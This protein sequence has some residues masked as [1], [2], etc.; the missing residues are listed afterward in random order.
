[1]SDRFALVVSKAS[2]F[3]LAE[4]IASFEAEGIH[5]TNPVTA[6]ATALSD[7]GDDIPVTLVELNR[8]LTAEGRVT[9]QL[10]LAGDDSVVCGLR[11]HQDLM[12][13]TYHFANP[14][15]LVP[16]LVSA[17]LKRFRVFAVRDGLIIGVVDLDGVTA[18]FDWAAGCIQP[19]SLL[20]RPDVIALPER[21]ARSYTMPQGLGS[22]HAGR[23]MLYYKPGLA[24]IIQLA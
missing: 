13:E 22:L 5:L 11:K 17:F 3:S 6:R 24:P 18:E 21:S 9:F 12:H 2:V 16:L 10:W 19:G 14:G 15:P 20:P 8:M 7:E 4:Q 1:M 23:L